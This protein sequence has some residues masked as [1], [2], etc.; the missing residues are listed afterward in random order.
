MKSIFLRICGIL[1]FAISGSLVYASSFCFTEPLMEMSQENLPE[2]V[3]CPLVIDL[4]FARPDEGNT[5]VSLINCETICTQ[6]GPVTDSVCAIPIDSGSNEGAFLPFRLQVVEPGTNRTLVL[7]VEISSLDGCTWD[8]RV[9]LPASSWSVENGSA[10]ES[11]MILAIFSDAEGPLVATIDVSPTTSDLRITIPI[12]GYTVSLLTGCEEG[13]IPPVTGPATTASQGTRHNPGLRGI[14]PSG[15]AALHQERYT[16]PDNHSPEP[17]SWQLTNPAEAELLL[18]LSEP[19]SATG[20]LAIYNLMGVP[21]AWFML[22][23]GQS[24]YRFDLGNFP[25]GVY[26]VKVNGSQAELLVKR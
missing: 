11:E 13:S 5:P 6:T 21:V 17:V 15:P 7:L 18:W 4:V 3:V 10:N 12:E 2:A 16:W 20:E 26:A 25:A 23:E 24:H 14:V 22:S 8:C 9:I 19:L 1:F